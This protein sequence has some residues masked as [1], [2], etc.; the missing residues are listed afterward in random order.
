MEQITI[1]EIVPQKQTIAPTRHN[2]TYPD[3]SVDIP[4]IT[5][6]QIKNNTALTCRNKHCAETTARVIT[7]PQQVLRLPVG[8]NSSDLFKYLGFDYV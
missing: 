8:F 1:K 5:F 6:S 3:D 2:P 7:L 4:A